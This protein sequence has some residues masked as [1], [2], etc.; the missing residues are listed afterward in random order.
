MI[1]MKTYVIEWHNLLNYTVHD[2]RERASERIND[3]CNET[4][5]PR[6][7][8]QT[9]LI[10]SLVFSLFSSSY[11]IYIQIYSINVFTIKCGNKFCY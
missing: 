6:R 8:S 7:V 1:N 10:F 2:T 4:R 11:Y 5:V 3:Y 9:R